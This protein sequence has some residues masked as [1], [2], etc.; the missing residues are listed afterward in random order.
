[1][2]RN[3]C[4]PQRVREISLYKFQHENEYFVETLM[5]D[6]L[7]DI[8]NEIVFPKEHY[9]RDRVSKKVRIE[10]FSNKSKKKEK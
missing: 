4:Q 10:L 7:D 6:Q 9:E 1:M 2:S 8:H 5:N 3:M